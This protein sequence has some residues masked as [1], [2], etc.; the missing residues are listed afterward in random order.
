MVAQRESHAAH[1][2]SSRDMTPVSRLQVQR[3]PVH[4]DPPKREKVRSWT[5]VGSW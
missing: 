4:W 2:C 5:E 3:H 1:K